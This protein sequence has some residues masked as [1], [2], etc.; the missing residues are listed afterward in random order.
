MNSDGLIK[1][2]DMDTLKKLGFH[3]PLEEHEASKLSTMDKSERL[4]ELAKMR[5]EELEQKR[6]R[7]EKY[8]GQ[9][10]AYLQGANRP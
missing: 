5:H 10:T 3:L 1:R 7:A 2:G 6:A 8:P 9:S 4:A